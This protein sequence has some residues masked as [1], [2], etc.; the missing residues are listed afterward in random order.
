MRY[1]YTVEP[2]DKPERW[3]LTISRHDTLRGQSTCPKTVTL[4]A[5]K[6]VDDARKKAA[7][8]ASVDPD[9]IVE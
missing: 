1:K 9:E 7:Q 4:Y 8:Y 2:K 5:C 3:K 6:D